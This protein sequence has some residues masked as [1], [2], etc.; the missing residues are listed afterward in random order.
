MQAANHTYDDL[1]AHAAKLGGKQA[2][3]GINW[4]WYEGFPT[5]AAAEA[6]LEHPAVYEHRGVIPM[7]E[8]G[9]C[10]YAVRVR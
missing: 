10:T 7:S 1:D 5:Q 9:V 6:F 8:A 4:T 3:G 2:S